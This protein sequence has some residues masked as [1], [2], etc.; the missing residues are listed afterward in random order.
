MQ[1]YNFM[2]KTRPSSKFATSA[3]FI[4]NSIKL[5]TTGLLTRI[6]LLYHNLELTIEIAWT[7]HISVTMARHESIKR[8]F[9]GGRNCGGEVYSII[10][11]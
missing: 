2:E 10:L 5:N 7:S 1:I 8:R 9:F 6:M 4:F 11:S 3:I